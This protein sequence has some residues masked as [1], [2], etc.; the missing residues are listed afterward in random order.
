[1]GILDGAVYLFNRQ[2]DKTGR[3]FGQQYFKMVMPCCFALNLV[4]NVHAVDSGF[5]K[6]N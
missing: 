4:V 5:S 2:V 6:S 1:L 3:N